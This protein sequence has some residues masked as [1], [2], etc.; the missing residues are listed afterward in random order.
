MQLILRKIWKQMFQLLC[1]INERYKNGVIFDDLVYK[2][3]K[4]IF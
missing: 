4:H 3:K 2:I 1:H